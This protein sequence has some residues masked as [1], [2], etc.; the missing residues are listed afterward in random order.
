MATGLKCFFCSRYCNVNFGDVSAVELWL[1]F[2]STVEGLF[3]P[4]E[5]LEIF[6][7]NEYVTLLFTVCGT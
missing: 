2:S 7:P 1:L 5:N 3:E 4:D 6:A